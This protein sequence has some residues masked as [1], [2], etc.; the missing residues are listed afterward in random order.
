MSTSPHSVVSLFF[1]NDTATTEIYT[2]SL[3]DALPI[4][5]AAGRRRRPLGDRRRNPIDPPER[6][7]AVRSGHLEADAELDHRLRAS[8]GGPGPAAPADATA[9]GVLRPVHRP[10]GDELDGDVRVSVRRHDPLGLEDVPAALRV[11]L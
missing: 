2:L 10:A 1:F 3:H 4:L 11:R 8:L 6:A 5:P 9:V 7:R